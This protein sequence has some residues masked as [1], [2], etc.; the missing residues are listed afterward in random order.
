MGA[1]TQLRFGNRSQAW[2]STNIYSTSQKFGHTFPSPWMRKC[3]QTFDWY[4]SLTPALILANGN[5]RT[6]FLTYSEML[7]MNKSVTESG[8]CDFH[9]YRT[10]F[11]KCNKLQHRIHDSK[12]Y[13]Y[14]YGSEMVKI[15]IVDYSLQYMYVLIVTVWTSRYAG[16]LSGSPYLFDKQW[17]LT[18]WSTKTDILSLSA[19][20][21][22]YHHYQKSVS[23]YHVIMTQFSCYY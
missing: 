15:H 20:L 3:V 1:L 6:A 21:N 19:F 9:V 14:I 7:H 23:C 13:I 11:S 17:L 8:D 10:I 16:L 22:C 5:S 18:G 4:C 2:I 12:E